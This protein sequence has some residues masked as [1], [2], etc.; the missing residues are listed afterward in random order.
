M[1]EWIKKIFGQ[2]GNVQDGLSDPVNTSGDVMSDIVAKLNPM[3]Q[4]VVVL[5]LI[6]V[7]MLLGADMGIEYQQSKAVT[8]TSQPMMMDC[9][10]CPVPEAVT[11]KAPDDKPSFSEP[12]AEPMKSSEVWQPTLEEFTLPGAK[13]ENPTQPRPAVKL[14]RGEL[15][16]SIPS[17]SVLRKQARKAPAGTRHRVRTNRPVRSNAAKEKLCTYNVWKPLSKRELSSSGIGGY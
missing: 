2:M 16:K 7:A 17:P 8:F 11:P 1:L 3:M 12:L 5:V 4:R 6:V 14:D 15:A 9:T 10:K 13:P